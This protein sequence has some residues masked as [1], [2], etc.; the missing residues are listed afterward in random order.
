ML[1]LILCFVFVFKRFYFNWLLAMT[2]WSQLVSLLEAYYFWVN[3]ENISKFA[4]CIKVLSKS[5]SFVAAS[6]KYN[7]K[8]IFNFV[9]YFVCVFVGIYPFFLL[10][11]SVGFYFVV[12]LCYFVMDILLSIFLVALIQVTVVN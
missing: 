3:A 1:Y 7:I 4:S 2:K 6:D 12:F 8:V 10:I 9:L 11:V 5:N